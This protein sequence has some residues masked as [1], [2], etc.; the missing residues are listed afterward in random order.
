[1][2]S[3]SPDTASSTIPLFE[4][5]KRTIQ[6]EAAEGHDYEAFY[7]AF[8]ARQFHIVVKPV[9][10]GQVG[11]AF[12]ETNGVNSLIAGGNREL[13]LE[14]LDTEGLELLEVSGLAILHLTAQEEFVLCIMESPESD[15]WL[16][17]TYEQLNLLARIANMHT[18]PNETAPAADAR[19]R[20]YPKAFLDWLYRYCRDND[21]I[22][23]CWFVIA[24]LGSP[25]NLD[26]AVILDSGGDTYHME[27][28]RQHAQS[29]FVAGVHLYDEAALSRIA[30][31]EISTTIRHHPPLFDRRHKQHFLARGLR[32]LRRHPITSLQIDLKPE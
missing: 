16:L 15:D 32:A 31:N 14:S 7:E 17:L 22:E 24:A 3:T 19:R 13:M 29:A 9:Q 4:I 21:D 8:Q 25:H 6:R 28:I 5:A 11:I 18:T 30:Q 10:N 26:V 2:P 23:R 1:M 20:L 27:R 12:G